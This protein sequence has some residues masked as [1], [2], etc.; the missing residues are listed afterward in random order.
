MNKFAA[1]YSSDRSFEPEGQNA[2]NEVIMDILKF[3]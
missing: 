2:I 1:T 3:T